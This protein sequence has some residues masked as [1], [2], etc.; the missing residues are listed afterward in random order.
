MIDRVIFGDNQFFGINHMSQE[1]AREQ[2]IRFGTLE[3]ITSV[4]DAAISEGVRAV[5]LNSNERAA[6]ICDHFRS[7]RSQ[8]PTITWYPS[9][10]YPHK[11][12]NLVAEKG[13]LPAIQEVVLG[14][15]ASAILG[16]VK[17][18]GSALV[19]QDELRL[20]HTLID[21][22]LRAFAGL[23]VRAVFLQNVVTDLLLG[24]GMYEVIGNYCDYLRRKHRVM[25]GLITQNMPRLLDF[26]RRYGIGGV[27]VCASFNK[28]GY[29]MS[30]DIA[31][32]VRAAEENDPVNYPLVAM[33]TLASGAIPPAEAY[34]FINRQN[35]QAIVFG[36]ST[37]AHIR[38]TVNLIER[39]P[40]A[41]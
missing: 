31:S 14:G 18:A 26:L 29:L 41:S 32:Y 8:I 24:L 7:R 15:G 30:P 2:A 16:M 19:F 23:E 4:Y 39:P 21:L 37:A 38:H 36:A 20:M 10:P 27:A 12:A 9:I 40:R 25:P 3:S 22:E 1:K 17:Q 13:I 34:E 5:M 28:I 33:S 6:G 35:L 11:Y